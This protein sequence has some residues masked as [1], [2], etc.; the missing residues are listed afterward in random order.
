MWTILLFMHSLIKE[1][2]ERPDTIYII[3][4]KCVTNNIV[5]YQATDNLINTLT[6]I[7]TITS[8]A[9]TYK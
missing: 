5:L 1:L 8:S 3:L 2:K 9:T 7:S 4:Q 6:F